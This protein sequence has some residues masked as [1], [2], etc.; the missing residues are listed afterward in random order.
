[1]KHDKDLYEMAGLFDRIHSIFVTLSDSHG[2]IKRSYNELSHVWRDR[3]FAITGA[4]LTESGRSLDNTCSQFYLAVEREERAHATLCE[5]AELDAS[6]H[7]ERPQFLNDFITEGAMT[8]GKM[9]VDPEDIARFERALE[10]YIQ[11]LES[12]V[13]SLSLE[14]SAAAEFWRDEQYTRFGESVAELERNTA[15]QTEALT[16]LLKLL[17]KKRMLLTEV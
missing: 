17:C 15:K 9:R 8:D 1:M 6:V 16:E 14:Y 4:A 7:H 3:V 13:K 12:E 10:A 5:Y 2:A 11:T